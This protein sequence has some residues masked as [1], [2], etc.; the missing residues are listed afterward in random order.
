MDIIYS[1][2]S[3][4]SL[5]NTK[6]EKNIPRSNNEE[7]FNYLYKPMSSYAAKLAIIKR[8]PERDIEDLV[9]NICT[10]V[11]KAINNPTCEVTYVKGLL[12]NYFFKEHASYVEHLCRGR[13]QT[14]Q[15]E[16]GRILFTFGEFEVR[17]R[18][19]KGR[20]YVSDDFKSDLLEQNSVGA[21]NWKLNTDPHELLLKLEACQELDYYMAQ[22]RKCKPYHLFVE[23]LLG[24]YIY[25]KSLAELMAE[26][27]LTTDQVKHYI[28]D[29][30]VEFKKI[31]PEHLAIEVR[32]P[33]RPRKPRKNVPITS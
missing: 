18:Y 11:W 7:F 30:K 23:L 25:E 26:Y 12:C 15:A 1:T 9:Q 19:D 17:T 27:N 14:P 24:K 21:G 13:R 22:L 33:R 8:V 3:P 20:T 32:Q 29:A 31:C 6:F 4:S 16:G 28:Q 2:Y 10:K 5:F